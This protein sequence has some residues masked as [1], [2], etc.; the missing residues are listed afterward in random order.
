MSVICTKCGHIFKD[1][2]N[3]Y[4][5]ICTRCNHYL[6]QSCELSIVIN[7]KRTKLLLLKEA[8]DLIERK[9][10]ERKH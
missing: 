9:K 7:N 1:H 3:K 4:G 5:K 6:P 2:E 8:L 10:N